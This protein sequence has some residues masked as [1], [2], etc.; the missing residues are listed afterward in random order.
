MEKKG[1]KSKEGHS[2]AI[3]LPEFNSIL[4]KPKTIKDKFMGTG[5]SASKTT[6]S[7]GIATSLESAAAA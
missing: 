3:S 4:P 6:A 2:L 1:D 7:G 5:S